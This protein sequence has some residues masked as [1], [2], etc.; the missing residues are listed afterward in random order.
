MQGAEYYE[1]C[2]QVF[3][4]SATNSRVS[5]PRNSKA[6]PPASITEALSGSWIS[7]QTALSNKEGVDQR[8]RNAYPCHNNETLAIR[9]K[10]GRDP[11]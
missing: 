1:Y 10:S 7:P 5:S 4:R 3:S 6:A 11:R 8:T 9:F 2:H